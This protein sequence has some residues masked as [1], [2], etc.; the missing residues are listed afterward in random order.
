MKLIILSTDCRKDF[1]SGGCAQNIVSS[2]SVGYYA[3]N[4]GKYPHGQ[5]R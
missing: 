2:Q 1:A 5:I 3:E 4:D